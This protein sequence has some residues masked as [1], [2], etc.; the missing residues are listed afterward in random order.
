MSNDKELWKTISSNLDNQDSKIRLAAVKELEGRKEIQAVRLMLKAIRDNSNHNRKQAGELLLNCDHPAVISG[1][2]AI[3]DSEKFHVRSTIIE[4]LTKL[5]SEKVLPQIIKLLDD[6]Q[7]E[8]SIRINLIPLFVKHGAN[9]HIHEIRTFLNS[10]DPAVRKAALDG[11]CLTN[12][13]WPTPL[14]LE[15]LGSG[16]CPE[17]VSKYLIRRKS[18]GLIKKLFKMAVQDGIGGDRA[19]A[20]LSQIADQDNFQEVITML[21]NEKTIIRCR[22]LQLAEALDPARAVIKAID[23]LDDSDE[24]IQNQAESLLVSRPFNEIK[25]LLK[26]RLSINLEDESALRLVQHLTKTIKPEKFLEILMDPVLGI[27]FLETCD[28]QL[29]DSVF[30]ILKEKLNT[31]DSDVFERHLNLVILLGHQQSMNYLK[32]I[33]TNADLQEKI[34]DAESEFNFR[35]EL[36]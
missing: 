35:K 27:H 1:M 33:K 23:L 24:Q 10:P 8:S 16:S 30:Q 14:L 26:K 18:S 19:I 21:N 29:D 13:E 36:S 31:E 17:R 15:L 2:I 25:D 4:L 32:N 5:E 34:I 6:D 22:G 3:L 12:D 20:I 28:Q 9:Q 11:I 7:L